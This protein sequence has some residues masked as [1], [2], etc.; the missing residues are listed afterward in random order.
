MGSAICSGRCGDSDESRDGGKAN[1]C[2]FACV[3][4]LDV[5]GTEDGAAITAEAVNFADAR[6]AG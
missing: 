2:K 1:Y 6:V 4:E 3:E 5:L